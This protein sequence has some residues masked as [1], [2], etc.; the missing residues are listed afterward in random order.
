LERSNC[1]ISLP[2]TIAITLLDG[3]LGLKQFSEEKISDQRVLEITQKIDCIKDDSL[4]R[5]LANFI[6]NFEDKEESSALG[7]NS[8]N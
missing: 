6:D 4:P 1:L 8:L 5:T 2:Y 7:K 3:E